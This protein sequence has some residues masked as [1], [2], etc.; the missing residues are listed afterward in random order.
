MTERKRH[1]C[2]AGAIFASL[3]NGPVHGVEREWQPE[4]LRVT[5]F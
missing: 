3:R 5:F 1:E 2:L 4:I